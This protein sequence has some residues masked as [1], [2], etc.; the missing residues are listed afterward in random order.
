MTLRDS[1][2]VPQVL[3][4]I[5]S[6]VLVLQQVLAVEQNRRKLIHSLP[7]TT[8]S[9]RW[10]VKNVTGN[11]ILRILKTNGLAPTLPEAGYGPYKPWPGW[12][13]FQA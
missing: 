10:Q 2:G 7:V 1:F 5:G 3:C 11:H 13:R 9:K 4:P 8:I 6:T 12:I